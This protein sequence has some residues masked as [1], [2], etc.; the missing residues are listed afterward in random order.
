[1]KNLLKLVTKK[2]LLSLNKEL[3]KMDFNELIGG[4]YEL[5]DQINTTEKND[6]T[7]YKE[8]KVIYAMID[9]FVALKEIYDPEGD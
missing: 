4:L 9:A 2:Q 5:M 6:N 7:K 3:E 1:M 8:I